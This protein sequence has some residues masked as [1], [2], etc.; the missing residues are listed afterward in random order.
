M[1]DIDS[2]KNGIFAKFAPLAKRAEAV[3]TLGR[4]PFGMTFDAMLSPTRARVGN[5]EVVLAG[6]NNYLGLTYDPR[7]MSAAKDA[8]DRQGTATTGSRLANGTYS[9]H[10]DLESALRDFFGAAS[11]LVC[12][13]GYQANLASISALAGRGDHLLIDADSH[14]CIYDACRLSDAETIRFRHNSPEDLAKRLSRL[15]AEGARLVVIEGLYSMLGDVAPVAEF[16]DVAHAHDAMIFVDEAHSIGCYGTN[17]RGVADAQGVLDKVDFL[18]GTFSKSF[19]SIG[20][21]CVS[22]HAAFE[23]VRLVSRP[24]LFTAS[25]SPAN[26]AAAHAALSVMAEDTSRME[27]LWARAHQLH[28]GL[29]DAGFEPASPTGPIIAVPRPDEL[30][31]VREWNA[32]LRAGIYVNI[33][34]PPATPQARSLLRLSVSAAHSEAEIDQIIG[35]FRQLSALAA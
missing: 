31:A 13:T 9:D 11:A 3:S 7:C 22:R 17:G 34:V 23:Y 8:I 35:A 20:G 12:T 4:Q 30:T 27:S 19:A 6:T 14:A 18:S 24:Y 2:K 28:A 26:V 10:V 21:F 1:F 5:A 32:L 15:P 29:V 25:G 16:V 33:A